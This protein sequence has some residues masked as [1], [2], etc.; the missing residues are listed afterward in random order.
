MW[1]SLTNCC[2]VKEP[3]GSMRNGHIVAITD[4]EAEAMKA[5]GRRLSGVAGDLLP[6]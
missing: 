4:L 6:C 1:M 2:G 3:S 5:T